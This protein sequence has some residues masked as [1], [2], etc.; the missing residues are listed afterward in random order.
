MALP[1]PT[2][3]P[4]PQPAACESKAASTVPF[5][6]EEDFEAELRKLA[7]EHQKL[8]ASMG[9]SHPAVPSSGPKTPPPTRAIP[10]PSPADTALIEKLR[11]ENIRLSSRV[12]E[13]EKAQAAAAQ[14]PR[15]ERTWDEREQEFE[16]LLAEKSEVIREL[17]AELQ[18]FKERPAAVAPKEQELL[19]LS[20][21]LENDRRQLE[22]DEAALEEQTK[23]MEMNIARQRAEI[24]RQRM[25]VER[26]YADLQLELDQA[27]RE[28][29][30]R[31]RLAPL[32]RRSQ[33]FGM[34]TGQATT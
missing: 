27:A 3:S 26:L 33:D 5:L 19:A 16:A 22:E 21:H 2:T 34:R 29:G 10:T 8:L 13:L 6:G 17:R 1:L 23:Q 9:L 25:E 20:E 12:E 30:L 4:A 7:D 28:S 32:Q 11:R 24:A 15:D 31:E 14:A 18:D